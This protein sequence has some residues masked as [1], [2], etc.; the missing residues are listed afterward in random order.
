MAVGHVLAESLNLL[1]ASL[2]H[3]ELEV[4][5][6]GKAHLLIEKGRA[7]L[8]AEL[9]TRVLQAAQHPGRPRGDVL[10]Q[11]LAIVVARIRK[12]AI[13]TDVGCRACGQFV[14]LLLAAPHGQLLTVV[15]QA[16][17]H[18]PIITSSGVQAVLLVSTDGFNVIPALLTKFRVQAEI[19]S[20]PSHHLLELGLAVGREVGLVAVVLKALLSISHARLDL[21]AELLF[22]CTANAQEDSVEAQIARV[23]NLLAKELLLAV[24]GERDTLFAEAFLGPAFSRLH[25]LAQH[26]CVIL[27]QLVEHRVESEILGRLQ[28]GAENLGLATFVELLLHLPEASHHRARLGVQSRIVTK[29]RSVSLA[30][31]GKHHVEVNVGSPFNFEVADLL[32]ALACHLAAIHVALLFQVILGRQALRKTTLA[33]LDLGTEM[34]DVAGAPPC[35]VKV[36]ISALQLNLVRSLDNVRDDRLLL[37]TALGLRLLVVFQLRLIEL[38]GYYLPGEQEDP[39]EQTQPPTIP[40][41]RDPMSALEQAGH[42]HATLFAGQE[43]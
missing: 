18:A 34:G 27:A 33:G 41:F 39:H 14:H 16:L 23:L 22:I 13:E 30:R 28:L 9:V 32:L 43:V 1:G 29:L 5:V 17:N 20:S 26:L 10:A 36:S 8:I 35:R 25:A 42:K 7:A 38:L 4:D 21:G 37:L 24:P 6:L 40:H 12:R 31:S 11:A 3:G 15:L 2:L 19:G